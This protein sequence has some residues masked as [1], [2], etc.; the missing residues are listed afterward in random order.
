MKIGLIDLSTLLPEFT[1]VLNIN[2]IA[3]MRFMSRH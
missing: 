1:D 2:M 3:I